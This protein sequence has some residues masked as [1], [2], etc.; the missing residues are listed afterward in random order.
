M[1][2]SK[3]SDMLSDDPNKLFV[4]T[5]VNTI[6]ADAMVTQGARASAAIAYT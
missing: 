3:S 1:I 6:T 5:V 4:N 2:R